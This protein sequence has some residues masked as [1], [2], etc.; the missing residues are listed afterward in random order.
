M[1]TWEEARR[2][3]SLEWA[4]A[5]DR[6]GAREARHD[7]KREQCPHCG[8]AIIDYSMHPCENGDFSAR[9]QY[10]LG[11]LYR[12]TLDGVIYWPDVTDETP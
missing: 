11:L 8:E 2:R 7:D 6:E 9:C 5:N 1:T 3:G 12:L 10:C 4:I